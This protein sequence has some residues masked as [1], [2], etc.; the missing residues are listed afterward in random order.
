MAVAG[1]IAVYDNDY[2]IGL[3]IGRER[4][5]VSVG[6]ALEI[7]SRLTEAV[8]RQYEKHQTPPLLP[9]PLPVVTPRYHFK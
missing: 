2:E 5:P 8:A 4:V 3:L 6:D 1:H 7:S 9:M